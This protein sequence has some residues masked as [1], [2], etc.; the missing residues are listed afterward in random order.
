MF[1]STDLFS[2]ASKSYLESQL[3][4]YTALTEITFNGTAKMLELELHTTKGSAAETALAAKQFLAAK[5]LHEAF[6]LMV[7]YSQLNTVRTLEFTRHATKI[8]AQTLH[9]YAEVMEK[10]MKVSGKKVQDLVED[11]VKHS[12][13]STPQSV[14]FVKSLLDA[15][16]TGYAHVAKAAQETVEA[17]EANLISAAGQVS[18]TLEESVARN[19]G[20]QQ[21]K[22]Q[23]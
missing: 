15:T 14:A 17:F 10:E 23:Y 2:S 20:K 8:Y 19:N 3:K 5:N 7:S 11:A 18:K 22:N 21:A 9:Q 6:D 1:S 4:L 16:N 13:G 12:P